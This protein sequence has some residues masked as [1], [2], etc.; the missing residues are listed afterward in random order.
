MVPKM[1]SG[2]LFCFLNSEYGQLLIKRQSYE[3]VVN[4]IDDIC[5][6]N[7]KIP[8]LS[9]KDKL[10]EIDNMV[11]ESNKLRYIAYKQEAINIMN[12]EVLGL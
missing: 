8:M 2:Y 7:I 1:H 12:K 11:L 10:N 5:M 6:G 3:S 9:N 4:M